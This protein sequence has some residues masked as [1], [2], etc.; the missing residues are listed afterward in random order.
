MAEQ[1]L[2]H[3]TLE[4][5]IYRIDKLHQRA[6]FNLRGKGDKE[7]TAGKKIQ[8]QIKRL[9]ASCTDLLGGHLYATIDLDRSRVARTMMRRNTKWFQSFH[10]YAAHSISKIIFT[11][12]DD[13]PIGANLIGR[14]YLPATEVISGQ[15]VDRWLDVLDQNKRPIQGG[16]KI[17]VRVKFTS[18]TQDVDWNKGIISS[19]PF[20]GVPNAFFNQREGC[21]VTLYQDAH[22]LGEYPDITVAGGQAIYIH[23]RC[24]EDIFDAIWDAKHL[25]YI[26]GWSVYP[27]I[28]LIRDPKRPRPGGNLKLGELLKKKAEENVT[29]L[30]LV[31]DD[32][33]SNKAFKRDG[34]MMTH[35][36]KT[37]DYFKN[38]KVRCVLCPRNPDNGESIVQGFGVA[39]MFT[40]HQKTIVVDAEVDGLKTRRRIVSFLGGIDLC[41]GRYDT[42][43]HPLFGTLNNV[44]SNDFHQPNFDGASIKKGGPREPWHDIH[45]RLDGPAAWD[46]L[47]NFEQRWLKQG[48]G[49]RYL[50]SMERFSEITVPPLPIV[51]PDDV[52]GWTVQVFRS[53]DNGAVEGFPEDP[54]EASSVGLVTGKNNVIERSIQDAYINAIRRA[55]HFIYIENQYFLGSSFG[56]NSRDVNLN[57][58][59]A[60]HL[61]PKEISLKIVS[62]IEAGERFSVYVVIPLWPEG[63]PGSASVQAILDWQRRTMEMMYTDIIIA[64]RKKGLDV[65]PRDYLTFFCLGN[66][67]VNKAGEYSPPEKPEANSDYARAQESR[68]FMIYVHSKMMI[69]DDEYVILGSANINQR[70]MDGGRDSEI[71]MGAYQPNHLLATNQMRPRGQVFSFRIS[72]WLEHLRIVT[73]TFQFPESEKCI[74]MVNAK[75][76]ELWGL[77][78]AQVYPRDHDLPG[79]L[80][81]Y[82]ISIGSNG[83][84]TSLAGVELFPDTNA[85]NV[86][87][88]VGAQAQWLA[89]AR[90]SSRFKGWSSMLSQWPCALPPHLEPPLPVGFGWKL[91]L[92]FIPY[93][94]VQAMAL[95]A[96]V[97]V[98]RFSD[99][100][101]RV[102]VLVSLTVT[103]CVRSSLT[104]QHYMGLLELLVVVC[105]AIVCRLGSDYGVQRLQ[106]YRGCFGSCNKPPPLIVAVDEPS[107][108]LRIQGRL[109]KKPSVSDD[110]WSTSTCD[111]D[112]NS[113]MQSQRSVSSISFTNNTATSARL[114]LWNQTRQQ[115]LASGSSQTKAKVRE[116]T[117]SWNATYESL[118]GVN[119]RFSR[120][121]P[122]PEM[123]DFLVDVWEQEGLYD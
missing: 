6:R 36:Q 26:T 55:K 20:K 121:I 79:H 72:L 94:L 21:K 60:L 38:T 101:G 27:D 29:V 119:K 51:R 114:N 23:H 50:V 2:L 66:R 43:E 81:S 116:P 73:N 53:I 1:L 65:N 118:L 67:E 7:P 19:P 25:I 31:W 34:L 39:A 96:P 56:W 33:T 42:E 82:P 64:L 10:V 52:E 13:E 58:I 84:V 62:K 90:S 28:T 9:A 71:A 3:G 32:R 92:F 86:K 108:G 22:V 85:K 57:E 83:E 80:L 44:H 14:A 107:K 117:I 91:A 105:E 68:R 112:N 106:P 76:D 99:G 18:V 74:R 45:C 61:I 97:S 47:Y 88:R 98:R 78:S 15:P 123:V 120:P 113:T 115:W 49:R 37:Y 35:D 41:D 100:Y 102:M 8:T 40:H 95:A 59:N 30:M 110:F 63:K 5:K 89:R 11:I 17:H 70:S 93:L 24:W 122:L 16:S 109:V 48:N 104:S 54:R 77:Y 111:M 69:V 12:K 4:V 75:A 46:V 103:A 87:F